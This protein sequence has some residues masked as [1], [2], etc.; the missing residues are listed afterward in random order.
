PYAS[1]S[2][3]LSFPRGTTTQ[4]VTVAVVGDVLDEANETFLV[5]LANATNAAIADGQGLGT[6]TDDDNPPVLSINDVTVTEGSSGTTNAVFTVSL[7]APSGLP[8]SVD[9]ATADG[10]AT[11]PAD[12]ASASGTLSFPRGTTTQT[13][14]VAVVGDVLDEANETF[15]VNLA[16]A[17]NAS[18][19]DGQGVGTITDDDNPPALSIADVTVTEGSSGTTNAVFTVSLDAPS[20]LPVTVDFAT[21]D[22]SA[23]A[24]ADYASASGT[25]SF[26]R[27]ATTQTITV[28]VVGDVLDEANETFLVNL[29]N[30]T[31]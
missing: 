1:A 21:A 31:N 28:A 5:N 29:A 19:G 15:L 24:P 3:T 10:S 26:P 27:G 12:Y 11:A 8:V 6:I 7:D 4:T 17:T 14:T 16:N 2:G 25:L 9:F 18:I 22:G 23:T 20:G 13:V 30:A